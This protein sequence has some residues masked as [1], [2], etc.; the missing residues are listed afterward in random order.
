MGH[1]S[2]AASYHRS[3]PPMTRPPSSA[4][5]SS[6]SSYHTAG[7]IPGPGPA[8]RSHQFMHGPQGGGVG[9]RPHAPHQQHRSPPPP[10]P[11]H[12]QQHLHGGGGP[13]NDFRQMGGAPRYPMPPRN[14]ALHQHRS[15]SSGGEGAFGPPRQQQHHLQG[16]PPGVMSHHGGPPHI[17]QQQGGH[18]LRPIPRTGGLQG[19]P[20]HSHHQHQNNGGG[21]PKPP[22]SALMHSGHLNMHH[23][24]PFRR[25]PPPT[26]QMAGAGGGSHGRGAFQPASHPHR[27]GFPP[28][29]QHQLPND[30]QHPGYSLRPAD[31]LPHHLQYGSPGSMDRGAV[32]RSPS[33]P[34]VPPGF[35][36]GYPAPPVL[37]NPVHQVASDSTVSTLGPLR[38]R[39]NGNVQEHKTPQKPTPQKAHAPDMTADAASI[40]LMLGTV[41]TQPNRNDQGENIGDQENVQE[42]QEPVTTETTTKEQH[43]LEEQQERDVKMIEESGSSDEDGSHASPPDLTSE[44]SSDT[45]DTHE[46]PMM[47]PENFPTRLSLPHDDA[48]LNSLHCFLRSELLEIFVVR[49]SANKKSPSHSPGSSVGRVGLRCVH[50][51]IVRKQ[52][53]DRDEA[54]MAVFYPKS[55]AEIYRLVT[56]W[57]RCHLRKCRSLPPPVRSKWQA[58]RENDKSRGKTHYW[59]TSAKEIGLVDCQSRAG[60][61]RFS[62]EAIKG[63]L[64]CVPC[65]TT[66]TSTTESEEAM[67]TEDDGTGMPVEVDPKTISSSAEAS[68]STDAGEADAEFVKRTLETTEPK[69]ETPAMVAGASMSVAV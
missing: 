21:H 1:G 32:S 40:L 59:V 9:P 60:G 63:F 64:K 50:C 17:E 19:L 53:N 62:D 38:E 30:Q 49:K 58:L 36:N 61:V 54:P 39:H 26:H 13:G 56:S 4:S 27:P 6:A 52:R 57:Q 22:T 46:P 12:Q 16:P 42:D 67:M 28:H 51:A 41:L 65:T 66:S 48:K 37:V 68:P 10:P 44:P 8:P 3:S 47:V 29:P 33:P 69:V 55:I 43:A 20:P 45:L 35:H 31:A 2:G 7:T 14:G 24:V 5:T 23:P 11:H 34:P 25:G 15:I 18:Q